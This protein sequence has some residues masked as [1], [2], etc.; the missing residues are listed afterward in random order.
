VDDDRFSTGLV[1]TVEL[2]RHRAVRHRAVRRRLGAAARASVL[3]RTWPAVCGELLGH[4]DQVTT[5]ILAA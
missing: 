5:A 1:S 2:L 4:Y 3:G